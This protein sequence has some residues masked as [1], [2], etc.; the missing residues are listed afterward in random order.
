M[1]RHVFP[2]AISLALACRQEEEPPRPGGAVIHVLFDE[3]HGLSGGESV[4]FHDF[5]VGS[6]EKVDIAEARVRATLSIDPEVAAQLTRESTFSVESDD[7]GLYL[8]AHVFDPEAEKL[9]EGGTLEGVDS[10]MELTVRQA[11]SEAS[12]FLA[13]IGS[14]EWA[15]E[16]KSLLSDVEREVEEVDW[17]GK[18]KE[19]RE[20]LE[21]ARG[22]ID[23]AAGKTSE[24]AK[25]SLQKLRGRMD[26]LVAELRELG[27]SEEA[28]KLQEQIEKLFGAESEG[29]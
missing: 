20:Q 22:A 5:E 13:R 4:R 10:G 7:S 24:Q 19:V 3:R 1:K 11:S 15:Q 23:E 8:L 16:A 28:R 2:V 12:R 9:G 25:E 17:G 14:S 26:Q 27:R 21:A 6:V 18:E 29:K